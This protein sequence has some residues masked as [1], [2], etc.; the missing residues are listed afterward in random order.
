MILQD[1]HD[2]RLLEEFGPA[3][4]VSV[5]L[6]VADGRIR[7]RRE[8]QLNDLRM[9]L[10]SG[11]VQWRHVGVPVRPPRVGIGAVRE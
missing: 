5:M 2:Y 3:F 4:H 1:P 6:A 8:E 7:P 11:E 10:R 9:T